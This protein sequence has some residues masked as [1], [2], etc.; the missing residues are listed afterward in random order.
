M[1]RLM[2]LILIA[3]FSAGTLSACNT[4]KGVGKDVEKVGDKVQ[5]AADDTGGTDPR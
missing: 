2:A 5:D 1:K 4:V 3:L